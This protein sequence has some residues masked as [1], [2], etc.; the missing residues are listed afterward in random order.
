MATLATCL[1]EQECIDNDT[2]LGLLACGEGL[3]TSSY[4]LCLGH[5]VESDCCAVETQICTDNTKCVECVVTADP[6]CG[7]AW[8]ADCV[9][10]AGGP[11]N[12]LCNCTPAEKTLTCAA[13]DACINACDDTDQLCIGDCVA[14]TPL[15]EYLKHADMMACAY[16]ADCHLTTTPEDYNLCL[17]SN[18]PQESSNCLGASTP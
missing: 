16:A 1:E 8:D 15:D 12:G 7:T 5:Q 10:I 11:C 17:S 14:A 3:C 2:S 9:A 13:Y 4:N 18:C 6:F